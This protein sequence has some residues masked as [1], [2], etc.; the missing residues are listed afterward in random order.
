MMAGQRTLLLQGG[1]VF[2]AERSLGRA[3]ALAIRGERILAVGALD[4][5]RA[6]A[7]PDAEILDCAGCTVLPGFV[8]AHNHF[9]ATGEDLRSVDVRYPRVASVDDLLGLIAEAAETMPPERTI[10]AVG[11]DHA[12]FPDG[13]APTRWDLDRVAPDHRVFVHHIS[14][15]YVLVNSRVIE[16]RDVTDEVADPRGGT[17]V[18]DETGRPNGLFLEAATRLVMTSAVDIGHHG[19][20]FHVSRPLEELLDGL[21]I[22][23]RSYHE[24]GITTVCDP[25]VTARELTAY[26][27]AR[28]RGSLR[29]RTACMPLSHELDE[30]FRIGLSGPFGDDLLQ[31]TGIKMYADGSLIGGTAAF[32]EPYGER[33]EFIGSLYWSADELSDMVGRAHAAGWQVGVH[34]QG[35]RAISMVVDAMEAVVRASPREAR[36]RIEHA[37]CPTREDVRRMAD[38]GI[39]AISQPMYLFD[40]GDEF[41][42]RLGSRA[43]RLQPLREYLDAGVS[44]VLSSDAFVASFRPV[45]A[46]AEAVSRRTREGNEIGPDE[47]LTVEEAV[48]SHTIEAARAIWMEDRLG[49]L[50]PDKLA[51]VVVLE[52]DLFS[53]P[54][55]RI[56]ELEVRTTILGGEVVHRGG[57]G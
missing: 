24:V 11:M 48:L 1:V 14:G 36:H 6:A 12:K 27:E 16:Q 17:V 57:R 33:G 13:Q 46:I 56:R 31:L 2:T 55:E 34:A 54:P 10:T 52:G 9:L 23:T 45:D 26:I 50:S 29:L 49:S 37:G 18:R 43:H 47:A 5:V 19:P 41:L 22:A 44:V 38:L 15:H 28:R 53:S 32:S 35:D 20:D 30:L 3:E 21:D 8:D 39:A 7:G 4:A 40:S 51:D 42:T 25:Q